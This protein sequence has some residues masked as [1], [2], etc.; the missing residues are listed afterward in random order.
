MPSEARSGGTSED[1]LVRQ[2][3]MKIVH[4][5]DLSCRRVGP[6]EAE[7]QHPFFHLTEYE[8]GLLPHGLD[9]GFAAADRAL[10]IAGMTFHSFSAA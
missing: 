1:N 9:C 4:R 10:P 2:E 7:R 6:A 8:D 3:W 5:I